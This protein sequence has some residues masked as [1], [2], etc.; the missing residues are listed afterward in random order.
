MTDRELEDFDRDLERRIAQLANTP[1]GRTAPARDVLRSISSRRRTLLPVARAGAVAAGVAVALAVVVAVSLRTG[2]PAGVSTRTRSSGSNAS[3]A[4]TLLALLRV[5]HY[6]YEPTDSPKEL[7]SLSDLVV[8]G[9]FESVEEGRVLRAS[10][11]RPQ[12][13]VVFAVSIDEV[14]GGRAAS[15]S[16][17]VVFVEVPRAPYQ[18]V[19]QFKDALTT[20]RVLLFL[21]DRSDLT[22]DVA[23]NNAGR[24][25][26]AAIYAP[27][28]QG[29]WIEG[30]DVDESVYVEDLNDYS[31]AWKGLA[32]VAEIEAYL[33]D[34]AAS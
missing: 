28:P 25:A 12:H 15:G 3:D 26:G 34:P 19:A 17:K 14:L 11:G 24:P 1:V 4:A 32:T 10:S 30:G 8:V 31:G 23:Q 2:D 21:D 27:L 9:H 22:D 7:A 16:D 18:T 13:Q 29:F 20:D 5:V 6:D 33:K